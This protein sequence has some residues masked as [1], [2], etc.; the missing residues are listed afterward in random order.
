MAGKRRSRVNEMV[1]MVCGMREPLPHQRWF[2]G[3]VAFFPLLSSPH[4]SL[5]LFLSLSVCPS[6]TLLPSKTNKSSNSRFVASF[7]YAEKTNP[8]LIVCWLNW[9]C[10][11][12]LAFLQDHN[13]DANEY[14]ELIIFKLN[15]NF[16]IDMNEGQRMNWTNIA[17][18]EMAS[19]RNRFG[20]YRN[21]N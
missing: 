3:V 4:L 6:S 20:L 16:L 15:I 1:S 11:E 21:G 2:V 17:S 7:A 19:S 12:T 13:R 10:C 18:N 9:R 5:S 14:I 8:V